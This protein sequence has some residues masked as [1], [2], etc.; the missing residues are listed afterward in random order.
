MPYSSKAKFRHEEIR[1]RRGMV[2]V[3][4]KRVAGGKE[5]RI[6]YDRRGMSH[7]LSVLTPKNY[8]APSKRPMGFVGVSELPPA[9][10][11]GMPVYSKKPSAKR[12]SRPPRVLDVGRTRRFRWDEQLIPVG[13]NVPNQFYLKGK[14]RLVGVFAL[15]QGGIP[16]FSHAQAHGAPS[17]HIGPCGRSC[18]SGFTSHKHKL[19]VDRRG[20]R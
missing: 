10:S 8:V 15:E 12:A 20:G 5:L 11:T 16:T 2:R 18:R 17:H 6:G 3:V 19:M 1:S 7:L 13:H 14:R 4:T 9:W